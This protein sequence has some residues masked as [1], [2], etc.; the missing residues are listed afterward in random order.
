[1][2]SV[3][4]ILDNVV[5]D[6]LPS[7]VSAVDQID[8]LNPS[9]S[10]DASIYFLRNYT[11]EGIEPYLKY[12]LY[13]LEINPQV[14][15]GEYDTVFQEVLDPQS[16]LY[17]NSPDLLVI[18]LVIE[19]FDPG[20]G[21]PGW[22]SVVAQER[23]TQ[24]L[25]T[26]SKKYQGLV[27]I[28]TFIS[29][30]YSEMGVSSLN[31]S[32]G[33]EQQI[34]SLNH[35][36]CSYA[37]QHASQFFIIDWGRFIK[38]LG[39]E[40]SIDYRYWYLSNAPFKKGFMNLFALELAKIIRALKGKAKKCLVLD[41]DNTLWGGIIGEDGLNGI[42][43]DN[44][45][46]PGKAYYDFQKT[47]LHLI[48]RGMLVTLCSK[49]NEQDVWQVF[50]QH[51]HCL[52]K[53]EHLVGWRINWN[54]KVS[55]IKSLADELNLGKDSFVFVDDS[56]VECD[57]VK[58][59]LPEITVLQPPSKLYNYPQILLKDALFDTLTISKEDRNRSM[60]YQHESR[61]KESE[62]LFNSVEEYL[63]SLDM[64]VIIH[65]VE[66]HE[67]PRV[68]QLTQRTNQFNLTT[69]RYS[70]KELS[71]FVQSPFYEV[72]TLSVRDK[73]GESGLTGVLIVERRNR[74]AIIDTLLLSCRV[75]GRKLEIVFCYH[76]FSL[77]EDAWELDHW[78]ACYVPTAKNH[79][80]AEFWEEIGFKVEEEVSEN[81]VYIMNAGHR[82]F[83][84]IDFIK[85][86]SE[87]YGK[88]N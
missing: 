59:L 66:D 8:S 18:T 58:T 75:L 2:V 77:L 19:T 16:S 41:C 22:T 12:Y 57:F 49:N 35:F 31:L 87:A 86:Y 46:Y 24:L 62:S 4:N 67:I 21:M 78:K 23:L 63:A 43:L 48:E 39:E 7:V 20:F 38:I 64:C 65:T 33:Q 32:S 69:K 54:D 60:L 85:I 88:E 73:F 50:E 17:C 51:P 3:R 56:S 34:E 14:L 79:Q 84:P 25:E 81:K 70:E 42:K 55:N 10:S 71:Q 52:L 29:P 40:K 83:D 26:L 80:V 74:V 5:L 72:F 36:I 53:K 68:A 1:M 76:C 37:Q 61:R 9:L 28:N 11:I 44:N 47:V 15:F 27:A 6:N 30:L 82:V 13:G 45:E